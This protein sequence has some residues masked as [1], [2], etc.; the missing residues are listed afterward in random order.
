MKIVNFMNFLITGIA[1]NSIILIKDDLHWKKTTW[2]LIKDT[3]HSKKLI[4]SGGATAL[5][6]SNPDGS[7]DESG[8]AS[9]YSGIP[10]PF[11]FLLVYMVSVKRSCFV[12]LCNG[13]D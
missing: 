8:S 6:T 4:Y 5:D 12:G 7:D 10:L 3:L 9:L 11:T 1:R 2:R 13:M